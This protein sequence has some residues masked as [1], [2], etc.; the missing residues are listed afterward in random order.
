MSPNL[1]TRHP[2]AVL[3]DRAVP[4]E[5]RA[6]YSAIFQNVVGRSVHE[7]RPALHQKPI[8]VALDHSTAGAHPFSEMLELCRVI[9]SGSVPISIV[10]ETL[11]QFQRAIDNRSS[12][13]S[14]LKINDRRQ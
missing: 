10:L 7:V 9:A 11:R 5:P 13:A 14:R 6:V 3:A 8:V 4:D 1:L 2:V 12:P